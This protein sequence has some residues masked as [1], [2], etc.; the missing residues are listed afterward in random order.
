MQY[1]STDSVETILAQIANGLPREG[2]L[3]LH[4]PELVLAGLCMRYHMPTRKIVALFP[5]YDLAWIQGRLIETMENPALSQW[6]FTNMERF[7][8]R[9][10]RVMGHTLGQYQRFMSSEST[11]RPAIAAGSPLGIP[12]MPVSCRPGLLP[13]AFVPEATDE[14]LSVGEGAKSASNRW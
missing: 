1:T 6:Y 11:P 12:A 8:S 3:G 14:L 10:R 7:D 2:F 13:G 4:L 9:F 5:G